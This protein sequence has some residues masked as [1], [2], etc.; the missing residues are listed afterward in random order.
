M[1]DYSLQQVASRPGQV[2]D[3]LVATNFVNSIT[4]GFAAVGQPNVAV[5]LV[6]GTELAFDD[7][8]QYERAFSLFGRVRLHHKVARFRQVDMTDPHAHHDALEFP[9]GRIVKV[10]R[11]VAGQTA[12]VLQLP[13]VIRDHDRNE[14]AKMSAAELIARTRTPLHG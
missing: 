1:C 8:V 11:L 12:T 7:Y 13:A 14:R 10:T 6:P 2:G 9:D 5:C 4:R 3:K